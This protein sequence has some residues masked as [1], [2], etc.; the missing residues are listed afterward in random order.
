MGDRLVAVFRAYTDAVR[1]LLQDRPE[2]PRVKGPLRLVVNN[3]LELTALVENLENTAEFQQLILG[4]RSSYSGD[5]HGKSDWAWQGAAKNFF[6]RSGYYVDIYEGKVPHTDTSFQNYCEAFQRREI[7]IGYLV[8]MEF[9]RF[10][11]PFMDLGTFQ[12]RRFAADELEA[13]FQNTV[14]EVF[15]PSAVIPVKQLENYWFVYL[16]QL[17][18]SPKL[19]RIFVDMSGMDRVSFEYTGY[20]KV[21]ESALQQLALFDWQAD[22]WKAPSSPIHKQQEKDEEIGWLGFGIPFVLRVDNNLLG[23][24]RRAPDFATLQAEPFVDARTGEEIGEVPVTYIRLDK[25][26]TDTFKTSIQRTGNLLGSL[27][28]KQ[29]DWR[30]LEVALGNFIKAFF[31]EGLEQMLWHITT[32]EAL[33]GEKGEGVTERLAR[34]IASILGKSEDERKAIRKQFKDLYRFRCDLVH[35]NPFQKPIYVGHLRDIRNLARRTLLWFLHYLEN[36]QGRI[37]HDQAGESLPT[38]EDILMLLDLD[39]NSRARLAWLID[40]LPSGF[41]YVSQWVE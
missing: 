2:S 37:P 8:P 30:F 17:A 22:W 21:I 9:V 23:S 1:S 25:G 10:A 12:L 13:I 39:E 26:E 15:Y 3:A 18:P 6:R 14:N 7:E 32:L 5:Y 29:N 40:S 19:G 24:P 38:R 31:A 27:G 4:T 34:R 20:P 28:A 41:P 36:I 33:L 35:G 11:E 16:T